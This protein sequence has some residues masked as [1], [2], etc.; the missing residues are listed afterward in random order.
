M[1][2]VTRFK[3]RSGSSIKINIDGSIDINSQVFTVKGSE[4]NPI[5]GGFTLPNA[6]M[7][8]LCSTPIGVCPFLGFPHHGYKIINS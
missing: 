3:H 6:T 7:G 8:P 4:E 1:T 5:G 2:G